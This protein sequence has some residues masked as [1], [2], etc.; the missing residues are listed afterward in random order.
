VPED[1]GERSVSSSPRPHHIRPSLSGVFG[2]RSGVLPPGVSVTEVGTEAERDK[3]RRLLKEL[4][5]DHKAFRDDITAKMESMA[6]QNSELLSELAQSKNKQ[7]QLVAD[8]ARSRSECAQLAKDLAQV[9]SE[10]QAM[11]KDLR[12]EELRG[13]VGSN[14]GDLTARSERLT[15][16]LDKV[17]QDVRI[18]IGD[19]SAQ[20]DALKGELG[21][22]KKES[23]SIKRELQAAKEQR[24]R[25][26]ERQKDIEKMKSSAESLNDITRL[27]AKSDLATM[28]L[29]SLRKQ[30]CER[31]VLL[32][33]RVEKEPDE[34]KVEERPPVGTIE[35]GE[36]V[37]T[38]RL[39]LRLGFMKAQS[40]AE[41][42]ESLS[43]DGERSS[44][45][46]SSNVMGLVVPEVEEGTGEHFGLMYG[47]AGVCG[48]TFL[49]QTVV[50]LIM[51]GN[52]LD[53]G[54]GECFGQ[55]PTFSM[56]LL[57]HTSKALAM[58]VAGTLMGKELM[59]IANYW[60][61]A[62][63]LMPTRSVE[64]VLTALLRVVM[65]LTLIG[66]NI[67]IFLSLTN[68]AEV[69]LN[70]TAL[71]FIASLGSDVLDV[72]KRGVFGH[73]IA[74][75]MTTTNFQLTFVSE[76]PAW[77]AHVRRVTI[78]VMTS[79]VIS[80]A[81]ITFKSADPMCQ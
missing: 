22:V 59:D 68:P 62:E 10:H 5:E 34:D 17:R 52:G 71:A 67:A 14:L 57:L 4:Y 77:F 15:S 45:L 28:E 1:H 40:E 30:L 74:K 13:L 36:D 41:E 37:F 53:M 73:H 25:L 78:T 31:G 35:L 38:A 7:A 3:N 9:R 76:Y 66:A 39:L 47:W 20:S 72:A 63:L 56:W 43:S 8:V 70:M 26:Q 12:I 2:S 18:Q 51:L 81:Y 65:N 50:L 79:V 29:Y 33:V 64:V 75:T 49:V 69:W 16:E 32:P 80:F 6:A 46:D 55:P 58:L 44:L 60:M 23:N 21:E 48:S 19:M 27:E 11:L 42:D 61:V 24:S 54:G